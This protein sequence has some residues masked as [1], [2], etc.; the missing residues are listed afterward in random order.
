MLS[1]LVV[2]WDGGNSGEDKA[3]QTS[4]DQITEPLNGILRPNRHDPI[5]RATIRL[6]RREKIHS[7][8]ALRR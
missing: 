6:L 4:R 7:L 1:Y 8:C 5:E 2:G 3:E